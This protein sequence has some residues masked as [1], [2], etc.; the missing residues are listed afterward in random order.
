MRKYRVIKN[1]KNDLQ[2]PIQL[3]KGDRVH[4]LDESNAQGDW[5]N[6]IFCQKDHIKGWVPKQ[7]IETVDGESIVREDYNAL[8]F[9]LV[10]GEVLIEMRELNGWIWCQKV[11]NSKKFAWAPL[12]H[13][14]IIE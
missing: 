5:P 12:N 14:E 10:S 6:W 7:I 3:V 9:N 1:Y 8:E 13:L 11:N 4:I 2:N